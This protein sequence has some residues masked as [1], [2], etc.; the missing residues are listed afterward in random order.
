[1]LAKRGIYIS[2]ALAAFALAVSAASFWQDRQNNSANDKWQDEVLSVVRTEFERLKGNHSANG[3][4]VVTK[5]SPADAS[6]GAP[7]RQ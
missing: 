7:Q 4:E 5:P 6:K 1:M 2:A 3:K